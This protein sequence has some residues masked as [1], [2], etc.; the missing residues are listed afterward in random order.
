CLSLDSSSVMSS[1]A[2]KIKPYSG[3]ALNPFLRLFLFIGVLAGGGLFVKYAFTELP[4]VAM[5]LASCFCAAVII[6]I[7]LILFVCNY[8]ELD[9]QHIASV[10]RVG[11]LVRYELSSVRWDEVRHAEFSI[12]RSRS[13]RTAELKLTTAGG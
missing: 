3:G 10:F 6:G 4:D 8:I 11:R 2:L 12:Q 9:E 7:I 13:T 5:R 1:P